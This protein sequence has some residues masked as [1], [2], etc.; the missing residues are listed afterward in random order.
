[1]L[2][3]VASGGPGFA[4]TVHAAK[5]RATGESVSIFVC[6][7]KELTKS[8]TSMNGTRAEAEAM[9]A[10]LRQDIKTMARIR[11]PCVLKVVEVIPETGKYLSVVTEPVSAR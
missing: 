6:D 8:V 4:W 11:H 5:V 1:V 10:H 3:P 2:Q 7:V 9:V